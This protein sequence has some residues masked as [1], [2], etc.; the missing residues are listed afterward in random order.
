MNTPKFPRLARQPVGPGEGNP[1]QFRFG[2]G[3]QPG[4]L[5]VHGWSG[6]PAEMRGLGEYLAGQGALTVGVQ[7]PGHGADPRDLLH[8]R[9]QHWVAAVGQELAWLRATCDTVFIGGLSMGGYAALNVALADPPRFAGVGALSP[10]F[11]V[12]PPTERAWMYSANGHSSLFE[13]A[14]T[15]AARGPRGRSPPARCNRAGR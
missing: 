9:W 12:S 2:Q 4:V 3:G 13:R 11:F 14:G 15:G 7:L 10:A 6:S 8:T 1:E 5:L